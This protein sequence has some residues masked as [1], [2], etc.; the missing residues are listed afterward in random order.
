MPK[1]RIKVDRDLC[2]GA[3]SCVTV[4]PI[5]F[6]LNSDNK[7][8]PKEPGLPDEPTVHERVIEVSDSEKEAILLAA[9]SCPTLAIFIHDEETGEQIFPSV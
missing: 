9:Q 5:Y 8:Y 4:A 1:L 7:A 6:A 2:I 3:A